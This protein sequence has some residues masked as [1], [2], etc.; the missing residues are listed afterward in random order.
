MQQPAMF[1]LSQQQLPMIQPPL[2]VDVNPLLEQAVLA[3]Q[4]EYMPK[5]S[6]PSFRKW[7][8]LCGDEATWGRGGFSEA[9]SGWLDIG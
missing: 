9:G 1:V 7:S 2:N 8:Y 5:T 6:M 4:R 3:I